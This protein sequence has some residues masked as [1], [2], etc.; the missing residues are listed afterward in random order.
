ME[1]LGPQDLLARFLLYKGYYRRESRRVMHQAFMP[2]REGAVSVFR[3]DDLSESDIWRIGRALVAD[4]Q[5]KP[6]HGR[7]E[8]TVSVPLGMGLQVDADAAPSRHANIT[9]WPGPERKDRQISLAQRLAAEATLSLC[10]E[11]S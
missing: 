8:I 1:D 5:G 6:L 3:T 4:P 10:D 9:G 7:A 2:N 11:P